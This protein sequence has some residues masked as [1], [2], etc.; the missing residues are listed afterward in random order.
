VSLEKAGGRGQGGMRREGFNRTLMTLMQQI[1]T[2]ISG[3]G[4][5]YGSF[6]NRK[7]RKGLAKYAKESMSKSVNSVV[8]NP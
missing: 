1:F 2:D 7:G 4:F 8:L 3:K 5:L 6:F